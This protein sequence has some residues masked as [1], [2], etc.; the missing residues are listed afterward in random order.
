M[1][2]LTLIALSLFVFLPN[3]IFANTDALAK[4]VG[5]N[6]TFM[7]YYNGKIFEA[8]SNLNCSIVLEDEVL[9]LEAP[10][11]FK[12][13]AYL[14]GASIKNQNSRL[15]ITTT[16]NGKRP[17]GS[18]CGDM[19]IMS[20]YKKQVIVEKNTVAIVQSFR[21]NFLE[22]NEIVETCTVK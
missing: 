13:L 4:L 20:G 7:S 21:C 6:G 16:E 11:Y 3:T 15:T 22:K 12:S 18:A 9:Y 5:K 2:K 1:S 8:E 19:G 10:T 17:G 14:E